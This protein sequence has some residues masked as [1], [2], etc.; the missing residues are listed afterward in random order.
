M[1]G[2]PSINAER[3]Q[4]IWKSVHHDLIQHA[5]PD[6]RFHFD[7]LSFTPDFRESSVAT[8]RV[9]E[10]PCYKAAKTLLVTPDNSLERLRHR[11]LK[12]GKKLLIG[13]YRLRRGF[14]LLN[15]ERLNEDEFERASW[16]DGME[17]PGIGRHLSL[18]QMQKEGISVDLCVIGGLAFSTTGVVVWEGSGL[19]EVQ[20]AMLQDIKALKGMTPVVAVAHSCQVVDEAEQGLERIKPEKLGEVQCDF[21]VTPERV[22]E[23]EGAV[24]PAARV[25]FDALDPTALDNIPPLQELKGIRMMDQIMHDGAFG[26]TNGKGKEK[27]QATEKTPTAEEQMGISMVERMMKGFKT[28]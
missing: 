16:L 17:R 3:R 27:E 5:L 18:A 20:F 28:V 9:V 13:T 6:S 26:E 8:D 12:D 11:A 14:V 4:S 10:L 25:Q 7:F 2:P 15:P 22:I 24:K 21:I 19:F 23:I 1:T